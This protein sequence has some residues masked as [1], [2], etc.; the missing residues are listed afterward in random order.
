MLVLDASACVD[1]VIGSPLAAGVARAL[2]GEDLIAPALLDVE[3]VSAVARLERSGQVTPAAATAAVEALLRL[4]AHRVGHQA[5]VGAAWA[6]RS[7]VRIHDAFYLACARLVGA[8][9]VTTDRRLAAV[10]LRD[11]TVIVPA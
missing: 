5:L 3:V 4:P 11:V 2:A 1:L 7:S 9:L 8:P 10:A 6:S